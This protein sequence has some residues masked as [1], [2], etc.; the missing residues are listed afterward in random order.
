MK[1]LTVSCMT[2]TVCPASGKHRRGRWE[3][4]H[5]MP[6]LR[7]RD[8]R[9]QHRV[10]PMRQAHRRVQRP[11]PLSTR[12]RRFRLFGTL[13]PF[14]RSPHLSRLPQETSRKRR[15]ALHRGRHQF[16][17][18]HRSRLV[19]RNGPAFHHMRRKVPTLVPGLQKPSEIS[20]ERR[21]RPPDT[22]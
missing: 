18:R 9:R 20:H 6:P 22:R 3:C 4:V 2:I 17:P 19:I 7:Q 11:F 8:R 12:P 10:S 14:C 15:H 16:S 21:M 5:S 1:T 13:V